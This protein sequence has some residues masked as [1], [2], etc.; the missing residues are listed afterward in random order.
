M[1][2]IKLTLRAE[3]IS[4]LRKLFYKSGFINYISSVYLQNLCSTANKRFYKMTSQRLSLELSDYNNFEVSDY[5]NGGK[6]KS[7]K[8]LSGGQTFQAAL[9]LALV[10]NIQSLTQTERNFFFLDEGFG[11]LDKETGSY[12]E[13]SWNR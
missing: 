1:I 6:L 10:D 9:S 12:I 8:T 3:D 2:P 7:A 4:T 5:M 11:S 13:K